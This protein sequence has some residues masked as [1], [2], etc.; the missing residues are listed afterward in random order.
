MERL[1]E[2]EQF[3]FYRENGKLI[4]FASYS[5][6]N[7]KKYYLRK[8]FYSFIN[9]LLH[10]SKKIKD[11]EGLKKYE[12]NYYYVPKELE[13]YFDGEVSM[14]IIDK[15]YRGKGLGKELLLKI[16]D[17]AKKNNMKNLQILSDESCTY[18]VYPK[19]GCE[20]VYETV[21][22]NMEYSNLGNVLKETAFIYEKK[23]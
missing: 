13:N 22:S 6:W 21:V 9:K 3:V 1:E 19:C 2:A 16:F 11:I 8:K 4:G 12:E 7:S 18:Q 17:L 23:L 15:N 14:L 10:K 5:K 20:K